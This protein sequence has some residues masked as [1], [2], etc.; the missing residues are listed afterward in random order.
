M[1]PFESQMIKR[2]LA[3]AE[4]IHAEQATKPVMI[5]KFN[6]IVRGQ[7]VANYGFAPNI[8]ELIVLNS[9]I[10]A[11]PEELS[12]DQVSRSAA[13]VSANINRLFNAMVDAGFHRETDALCRFV[14]QGISG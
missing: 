5:A 12:D 7:L 9:N 2:M 13:M 10:P 11:P 6:G 8:A 1:T 4:R 3:A 14:G